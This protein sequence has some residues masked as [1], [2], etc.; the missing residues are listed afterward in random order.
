MVETKFL[1]TLPDF[2]IEQSAKENP[3]GRNARPADVVPAVLHLLRDGNEF[4]T[5]AV[6]PVTGGSAL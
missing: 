2:A 4:T 5:G 1:S 3:A 6:L